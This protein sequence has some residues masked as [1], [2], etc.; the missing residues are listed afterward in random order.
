LLK[1]H[2]NS[3]LGFLQLLI[4]RFQFDLMHLQLVPEA[5]RV[6]IRFH[7]TFVALQ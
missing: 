2:L 5:L 6:G 7:S 4:L 3:D 1:R